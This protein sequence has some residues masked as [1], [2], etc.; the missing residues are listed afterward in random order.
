M[1]KGEVNKDKSEICPYSIM[2]GNLE[3][4]SPDKTGKINQNAGTITI[5]AY[6]GHIHYHEKPFWA[7]ATCFV[8]NA[9]DLDSENLYK[10]LKQNEEKVKKIKKELQIKKPDLKPCLKDILTNFDFKLNTKIEKDLEKYFTIKKKRKEGIKPQKDSLGKY[11]YTNGGK[12]QKKEYCNEYNTG[13]YSVTI[14][15]GERQKNICYHDKPIFATD[16]CFVMMCKT[17]TICKHL[18][19]FLIQKQEEINNFSCFPNANPY[20]MGSEK[21]LLYYLKDF[22]SYLEKQTEEPISIENLKKPKNLRLKK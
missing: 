17:E 9:K 15:K 18:Y 12:I 3:T 14:A 1:K 7:L 19:N 20:Y 8:I 11:L 2:G 6:N 13:L 4:Y 21:D 5:G 16:N 22:P 10:F